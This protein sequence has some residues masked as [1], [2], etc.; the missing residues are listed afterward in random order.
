[1][2]GLRAG[3]VTRHFDSQLEASI[4]GM[5]DQ[6]LRTSSW[7]LFG[8]SW[9]GF[10]GASTWGTSTVKLGVQGA[11]REDMTNDSFTAVLERSGSG[12]VDVVRLVVPSAGTVHDYVQNLIW[13]WQR[14]LQI[15]SHSELVVRTPPGRS[16]EQNRL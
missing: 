13:G 14:S 10:G 2:T 3:E 15:N 8:N 4:N 9:Y 6:R 1:M 11:I 16:G 12:G 7:E 5:L